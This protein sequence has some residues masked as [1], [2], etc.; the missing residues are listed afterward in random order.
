MAR[1]FIRII[2]SALAFYFV[3]P[4]LDGIH[5]TGDF[6]TALCLG[7]LFAVIA[8][9]AAKLLGL[10]EGLFALGTL[11]LGC[12]III[13]LNLVAFWVLP[14]LA[15]KGVAILVPAHFA[16][17]GWWPAF[18]GGLILLFINVLTRRRTTETKTAE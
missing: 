16:V 14:A 18:L 3:F 5:M 8:W 17:S 11:G 1:T 2:L 12:L 9:A 10:I 6:V 15:L 4:M 13:P 7:A